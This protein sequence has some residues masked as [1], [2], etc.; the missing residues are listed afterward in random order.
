MPKSQAGTALGADAEGEVEG[1]L[2]LSSKQEEA[3]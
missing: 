1:A 2:E 3:H